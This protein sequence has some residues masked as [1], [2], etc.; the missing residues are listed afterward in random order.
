MG[1]RR[2]PTPMTS[3]SLRLAAGRTLRLGLLASVLAAPAAA[4]SED[5]S[6]PAHLSSSVFAPGQPLTLTLRGQTPG[7]LSMILVSTGPGA[8]VLPGSARLP[9]LRIGLPASVLAFGLLDDDGR[10]VRTTPI[11]PTLP[12][13]ADFHVQG[14]VRWAPGGKVLAKRLP[15]PVQSPLLSGAWFASEPR[16]LTVGLGPVAF[17]DGTSLLDASTALFGGSD[18]DWADFDRD[19]RQDVLVA[20]AGAGAYP[21]L[22]RNDSGLLVDEALARLP[23]AAQVPSACLEAA[24]VD[25]D[26]DLDLFLGVA[27][28][29]LAPAANLLLQN[30]G[31]GHFTPSAG[32]PG[33]A[34][35]PL[36]AEFGDLDGDG[37]LDLVVANQL[38][39]Q[40]PG[41]APDAVVLYV[42]LGRRQGGTCGVFLPDALFGSLPGNNTHADGGD[43]SLGDV[44]DDGD[45]DLHVARTMGS[46]GAQN[47]LYLNDGLGGLVEVTSTALPALL[48]NSFEADFADLDGDGR[49]DLVVANSTST[50]VPS[51]IHLLRNLGPV[52]PGGTPVF[53]DAST[54]LPASFG[55]N[56]RVR[57][58]LD[59]GDMDQDGDVDVAIGIHELP[60][61]PPPAT[62]G[63]SVLL[64][65]QGGNQ[66]GVQGTFALAAGF[67]PFGTFI[68]S[69]V[70]FGDLDLDGD[71]ELYL[72]NSGQLFGSDRQ[73]RLLLNQY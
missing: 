17:L 53:A 6:A 37:D 32:L 43:V 19:G 67:D 35:Q 61:G 22:L 41:E 60:F 23:P 69:D 1:E 40:H 71:L 72:A 73:D 30:D 65:N 48:D 50:A 12:V 29:A 52:G 57:I 51:G 24:D 18:V 31:N 34:G 25:C 14:F 3:F 8:T 59:T 55:T 62:A 2:N 15:G 46:N 44:D 36:D 42:N 11:P 9:V 38:D 27:S 33:G 63:K 4:D 56:T 54:D 70:A 26:G 64:V 21:H 39:P 16:A 10:L 13:G 28:D 5:S 66:G 45:L 68:C 47:Q 58:S 49:L 20:N 7:A